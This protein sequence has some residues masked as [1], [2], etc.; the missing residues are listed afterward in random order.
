MANFVLT[1]KKCSDLVVEDIPDTQ[2]PIEI[3]V[4]NI[5]D[6]DILMV[7]IKGKETG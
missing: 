7:W 5:K 1:L 6:Y 4:E 2:I 3:S